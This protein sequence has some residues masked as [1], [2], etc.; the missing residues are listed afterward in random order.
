MAAVAGVVEAVEAVAVLERRAASAEA[1]A[2]READCS[3]EVLDAF[4]GAPRVLS[5]A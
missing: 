5:A 3:V 1:V 2:E 4:P